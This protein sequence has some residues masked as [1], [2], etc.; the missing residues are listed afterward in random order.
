MKLSRRMKL[1]VVTVHVAAASFW[2]ALLTSIIAIQAAERTSIDPIATSAT[3]Q[4]R[5]LLPTVVIA[6]VSG[7]LLS[8]GTQYGFIKHRWMVVKTVLVLA[9]FVIATLTF[10]QH[11]SWIWW[12]AIG[13]AIVILITA[14]SAT[15]PFGRTRW[16]YRRGKHG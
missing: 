13:L 16:G 14:I 10:V 11:S 3:L 9:V 7:L 15:K 5:V 2:V 12:R 6:V 1:A 8:V 4:L